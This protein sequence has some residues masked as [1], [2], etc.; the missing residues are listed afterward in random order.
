MAVDPRLVEIALANVEGAAFERFFQA[1]YPAMSTAEFVPLGGMHDGGADAFGGDR[2]FEGKHKATDFY[3]ASVQVD[4]RAKIKQT[5]KRLREFGRDVRRL[6]YVTS[7][8]IVAL[9]KDEE[10]LTR[11]LD[12]T[13]RIRHR[14]W[15]SANINHSSGT[16]AAYDA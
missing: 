1:F 15:I 12:L 11:E 5:V 8:N 13:I 2:V 10:E 9:D 7:Q 4:H 6:T 14:K 3:Q 16:L